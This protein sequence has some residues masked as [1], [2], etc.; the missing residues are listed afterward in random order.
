[1]SNYRVSYYFNAGRQGW[2]EQWYNTSSDTPQNVANLLSNPAFLKGFLAMRSAGCFLTGVRVNDAVNVRHSFFLPLNIDSGQY[3]AL[4]ASAGEAPNVAVLGY[5]LTTTGAR[6]SVMVR[7]LIDVEINRDANDAWLPSG[8]LM[9]ALGLYVGVLVSYGMQIRVLRAP[10]NFNPDRQVTKLSPNVN[11]AGMT[12]ITYASTV[13][14]TPFVPVIM[15]KIP[16][17]QLPGYTGPIPSLN[18]TNVSVDVP[19]AWRQPGVLVP[20][21]N[22]VIR[23]A[24]FD[25][26]GLA[27]IVWEDIRTKRTGRPSLTSRGRR[28]GVKYRSR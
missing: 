25:Y 10:D 6:R 8:A 23:N 26:I 2:S 15:H 5:A 1:M 28:P 14:L 24:L 4:P 11:D 20:I 7:G 13:P 19:V 22:G 18:V 3:A 12:T 9:S 16:R 17:N 21:R 27:T